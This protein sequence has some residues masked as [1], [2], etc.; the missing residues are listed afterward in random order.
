MKNKLIHT[1]QFLLPTICVCSIV[2]ILFGVV[3][4]G[5]VAKSDSMQPEITK[6]EYVIGNRLAY[7]KEKP[8]IDDTVIVKI[9]NKYCIRKVSKVSKDSCILEDANK[10][11]LEVSTNNIVAKC[12]KK[13]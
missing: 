6:G 9:D 1:V 11:I 3:L 4:I 7:L 12:I 2:Y 13:G 10:K 5:G 8:Q